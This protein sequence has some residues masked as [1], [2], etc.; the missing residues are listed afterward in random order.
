MHSAIGSVGIA[1]ERFTTVAGRRAD[2]VVNL[3]YHGDLPL[4]ES[5]L[6]PIFRPSAFTL[7]ADLF[8]G[9]PIG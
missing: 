1:T 5:V 6:S 4:C 8:N 2:T 9:Y 3:T 7:N